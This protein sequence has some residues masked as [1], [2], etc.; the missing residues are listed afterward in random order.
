MAEN[1]EPN[2]KSQKSNKTLITIT[3]SALVVLLGISIY[4]VID[5]NQKNKFIS[6]E[7]DKTATELETIRDELDQKIIDLENLGENVDSL[8]LVKTSLEEEMEELKQDNRIAWNRYY[9]IEKKVE[10]Y[11]ELLIMKDKEIAK[12]TEINEELLTENKDLKVEKNQLNDSISELSQT[13]NELASKVAKA[14][15]LEAENIKV[16]AVNNRGKEREGEFKPR[17]IEQLKVEFSIAK[18]DVAP[19][20]GKDILIRILEPAGNVLFDVA[21]GSGTFMLN[22]KE[23]FFTAKQNI[24]F[25]N[26]QQQLTFFY[27]QESEF[28]PGQHTLEVYTD[29]YIMGSEYFYVK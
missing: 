25:D 19:V 15:Q 12:L 17:H 22:G 24:L 5:Q 9:K 7:L 11:R 8:R 4:F 29:G 21:K 13:K 28:S 27:D 2:Q 10:G 16:Y 14:S 20:E 26:T 6:S 23:E 3:I 1:R 18:N